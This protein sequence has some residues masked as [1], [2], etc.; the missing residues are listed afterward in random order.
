MSSST[1]VEHKAVYDLGRKELKNRTEM[2][3]DSGLKVRGSVCCALP[4]P[5]VGGCQRLIPHDPCCPNWP[6]R[7]ASTT[8]T[9]QT[10]S[11]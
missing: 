4:L 2:K 10:W 6:R 11:A 8:V 1:K 7:S 3:L 5:W 9:R